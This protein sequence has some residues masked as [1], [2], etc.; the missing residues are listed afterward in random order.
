MP[1]LTSQR[2][3]AHVPS[4]RRQQQPSSRLPSIFP[5]SFLSFIPQDGSLL[6]RRLGVLGHTGPEAVLES[7]GD[8]LEVAH[9]AGADGVS[10]LGLLAP[11]VCSR[12]FCHVSSFFLS[13]IFW[14]VALFSTLNLFAHESSQAQR[15]WKK[16]QGSKCR[17]GSKEERRTLPGLSSRVAARGARVLLDVERA[18]AWRGRERV[19]S[20]M[21]LFAQLPDDFSHSI[22]FRFHSAWY[23]PPIIAIHHF[24]QLPDTHQ[25]TSQI[26]ANFPVTVHHGAKGRG[27]Y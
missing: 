18:T 14:V 5:L 21:S 16:D 1:T 2:I 26:V 13:F 22:R 20:C 9:A 19:R 4:P 12:G 6:K 23:Q 8:V 27:L 24:P 3:F 17:G 15:G 7:A 11:V 10:A 25:M